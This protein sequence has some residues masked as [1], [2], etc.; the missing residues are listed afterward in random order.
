MNFEDLKAFV[1][2]ARLGGYSRA[3]THFRVAQSALS[4]RIARLEHQLGVQLLTRVGRGVQ[5]TPHGDYLLERANVLISEMAAIEKGI[6]ERG[7]EP[8]GEVAIGLPPTSAQVLAPL[9]AGDLKTRFPRIVLRIREGFSGALHEWVLS[10]K[11]DLALLYDP[12]PSSDLLIKPLL[13]EPIKLV[14][15][16]ECP[17]PVR[18]L[19]RNGRIRLADIGKIPLIVPTKAHSIRALLD[20]R[21]VEHR[22]ALNIAYE[23]DGMR[24]T[25]AMV[26][27]GLGYT[28]FSYAGVYEEVQAGTLDVFDITP[29]L[30]WTLSLVEHKQAATSRAMTIVK[31]LIESHARSLRDQKL[32]RGEFV[33]AD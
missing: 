29:P 2:V 23:V 7:D 9:I 11:V 4:R 19:I 5:L 22:L 10:R 20:R 12:E 14:C 13:R 26:E 6:L 30:S 25:K 27:A 28:L 15:P 17:E 18:G 3:A 32:W 31:S 21:A 8:A 24:A 16:A 1:L 33:D